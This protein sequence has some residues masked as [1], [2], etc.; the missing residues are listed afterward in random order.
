[1]QFLMSAYNFVWLYVL[2]CFLY[3]V[4][5]SLAGQEARLPG[6]AEAADRQVM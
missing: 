2:I 1:M 4:A 5:A 3:G 6:V